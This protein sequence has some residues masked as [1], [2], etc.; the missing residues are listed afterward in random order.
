VQTHD[1][2]NVQ[3]SILLSLIGGVH[4]KKMC[5]SRLEGGGE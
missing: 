1:S 2:V 3:L 4:W 5:E